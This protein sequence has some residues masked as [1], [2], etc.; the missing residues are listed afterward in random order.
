[1]RDLNT[2]EKYRCPPFAALLLE[3]CSELSKRILNYPGIRQFPDVLALGYW[4]RKSHLEAIKNR[5]EERLPRNAVAIPRG[6]VFH[7]PPANVDTMFVYSWILSLLAGNANI[8]RL[9]T[10]SSQ[11]SALLIDIIKELLNISSFESINKSTYL[12]IYGHEEEITASCSAAADVRIIWGGDATVSQI[13]KIPLKLNGREMVFPDRFAFAALNSSRYLES[14]D[15][16]RVKLALDFYNDVYWFDQCG[17]ASS[18]MV[19]WIG[20]KEQAEQA[21]KIFYEL[22]QHTLKQKRY[23]LPLGAILQKEIFIYDKA[24][25]LEMAPPE[26]YTSALTVLRLKRFESSCREHCGFGLLYD[27]SLERLDEVAG[28]IS[29]KDQTL[30]YFGFQ[31]EEL[32]HLIDKINGRGIDRIVPIGQALRFNSLWDGMD[33]LSELTRLVDLGE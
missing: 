13:R 24:L 7:I 30:T 31:R 2:L 23:E 9:P 27:L 1:M 16:E 14:K 3:F 26:R 18:R 6:M 25:S 15:D 11:G 21:R 29:E 8:V 20:T 4:L 32:L 5:F 12:I 33:L 22:L 28:F 17:C 19:V 10:K